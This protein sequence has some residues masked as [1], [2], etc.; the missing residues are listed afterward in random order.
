MLILAVMAVTALVMNGQVTPDTVKVI[1]KPE[2][3]V[4]TE[5]EGVS[6]VNVIEKT[7]EEGTKTYR[8][9]VTKAEGTK[10]KSSQS[11]E[12]G[13]NVPLDNNDK[14]DEDGENSK[15]EL[16][17]S[18]LYFGWGNSSTGVELK[19]TFSSTNEV[20]I[21]NFVGIGY[22]PC[23][24]TRLSLG[25]G[26]NHR[27]YN[28]KEPYFFCKDLNLKDVVSVGVYPTEARHRQSRLNVTSMQ[29]PIEVSQQ[30][31]GKWRISLAAVPMWNFYAELH[32]HFKIEDTRTD[33][34]TNGL[35]QK[36]FS[37]DAIAAVTWRG[38]GMYFRY[39]PSKVFKTGYG[40]E[41]K[42]TWLL[43]LTLGF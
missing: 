20:G 13:V 37:C 32:R 29:F 40:P 7:N 19:N 25:L 42:N 24:T 6:H 16:F 2:K 23:P 38:L 22:N 14:E 31:G 8:Y 43:G 18:G 17:L 15:W 39:S 35:L 28:L 36:K 3:V 1:D 33:E 10:S 12:W 9:E 41:I 21:L 4:I 27:N 5:Q 34:N 30:I 26:F 11:F